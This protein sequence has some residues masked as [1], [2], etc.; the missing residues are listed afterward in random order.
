MKNLMKILFSCGII[1]FM[2]FSCE[3]ENENS[4]PLIGSWKCIGFGDSETNE[5]IEI[6]PKDC[7]KCYKLT[8]K[9]DRTFSGYSVLNILSG[10]Y[11][12]DIKNN[13]LIFPTG[14]GGTEVMEEGDALLFK[15]LLKDAC[16]YSI[17]NKQLL[18][19][20]SDNQYLLFNI[21][22]K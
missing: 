3:E 6:E 22:F 1:I 20:Y 9:E 10:K 7:E 12:F 16:S 4:N 5:I 17:N 2:T 13:K 14:I 19:Y 8:F 18:I 11:E 21:I 15:N